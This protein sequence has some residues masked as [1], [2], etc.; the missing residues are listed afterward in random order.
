MSCVHPEKA[1][2]MPCTMNT[3]SLVRFQ[4]NGD[5]DKILKARR[6]K[7]KSYIQALRIQLTFQKQHWKLRD[8]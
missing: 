5:K 7:K 6:R 3:P 8:S 2:Q 1:H 4:N